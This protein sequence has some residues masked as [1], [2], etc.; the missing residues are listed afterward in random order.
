MARMA[1][2][3]GFIDILLAMILRMLLRLLFAL[4]SRYVHISVW[5]GATHG[6]YRSSW[7]DLKFLMCIASGDWNDKLVHAQLL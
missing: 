4:C 5:V 3:Y 2:G 7:C 1:L 6:G